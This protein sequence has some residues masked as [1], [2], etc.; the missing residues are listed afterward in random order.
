MLLVQ[1]YCIAAEDRIQHISH[2]DNFT[3]N[4]ETFSF[5]FWRQT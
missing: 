4:I 5:V 1:S 3:D 2:T